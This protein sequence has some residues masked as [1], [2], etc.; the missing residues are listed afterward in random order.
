M[1][2][3]LVP[4]ANA[5][6]R[7]FGGKQGHQVIGDSRFQGRTRTRRNDDVRWIPGL[8]LRGGH[9]VI[10]H[11]LKVNV[12][13][14]FTQA[15]DQVI[16]EGVIVIDQDDHGQAHTPRLRGELPAPT[17]TVKWIVTLVPAGRKR[18]W[19]ETAAATAGAC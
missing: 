1:A 3:A 4:E 8:D 6:E 10:S 17:C 7:Y 19:R 15:L 18:I 9:L 11:D 13:V 2:N 14:D 16:R 12:R 5:Q